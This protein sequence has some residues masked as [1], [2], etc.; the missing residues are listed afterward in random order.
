MAGPGVPHSWFKLNSGSFSPLVQFTCAESAGEKRKKEGL[1][2]LAASCEIH[3]LHKSRTQHHS[4][5]FTFV[6]PVQAHLDSKLIERSHV[7]FS[8]AFSFA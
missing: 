3:V 5:V 7:V 6:S 8:D 1:Y 2:R 4:N